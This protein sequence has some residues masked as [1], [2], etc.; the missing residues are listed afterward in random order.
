MQLQQ[1]DGGFQDFPTSVLPIILLSSALQDIKRLLL[2][3]WHFINSVS[4]GCMEIL[5]RQIL[6]GLLALRST[7]VLVGIA[8]LITKRYEY[9]FSLLLSIFC[10][11]HVHM[12]HVRL[13][14]WWETRQ[15]EQI[16]I[17][18]TPQFDGLKMFKNLS[19]KK[20][21]QVKWGINIHSASIYRVFCMGFSSAG[22]EKM[23]NKSDVKRLFSAERS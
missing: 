18:L 7:L 12:R 17:V 10:P 4:T 1:W 13:Q 2:L 15:L 21:K 16:L 22:R 20:K 19:N 5:W 3:H 23:K 14:N 8:E 6:H 9:S 11:S